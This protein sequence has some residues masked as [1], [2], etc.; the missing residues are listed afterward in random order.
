MALIQVSERMVVI[1]EKRGYPG[2]EAVLLCVILEPFPKDF[3]CLCRR[4]A[5]KPLSAAG[6]NEI[7]LIVDEPVFIAVLVREHFV[8]AARNLSNRLCHAAIVTRRV[9]AKGKKNFPRLRPTFPPADAGSSG[10][11]FFLVSLAQLSR[12][13]AMR[14]NTGLSGFESTGSTKK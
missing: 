13:V 2:D 9:R 5:R 10:R 7:D 8:T 1:I 11:Y 4:E 12:S 14:L 6:G 3:F